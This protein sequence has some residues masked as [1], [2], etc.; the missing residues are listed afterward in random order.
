LEINVLEK[1]PNRG[2]YIKDIPLHILNSIRRTMIADV[3][4]MAIDTVVFTVNSTIFYDEYI[5]HRLGLVPLT[6][7]AALEKYKPPEECREA[8]ERGLFTEDCFVKLDLEG[9]NP[10]GS[11]NII[12][13][14]SGDL[15]TSDPDVK[16]VYDKIPIAILSPGQKISLEAYARLGRGREHAKWSPVSVAAHKF[17]ADIIIDYEKCR[18]PE[19][20]DCINVCPRNI[21]V[22]DNDKVKVSPDKLF[23]C[24]LC[25]VCEEACKYRAIKINWR[26]NEYILLVETTGALSP[27]RVLLE[28]VKVLESKLDNLMEALKMEGITK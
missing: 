15:R 28:A 6:S 27:K 7:E 1:A 26:K 13:L 9:E 22:I 11:N 12:T 8:S 20:T 5:A 19:C 23:E 17:I 18:A 3:P 2:M 24:S 14:Y 10:P 4:T 21:L 25:R 16:P